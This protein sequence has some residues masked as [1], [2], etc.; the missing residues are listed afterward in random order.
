ML[1]ASEGIT[2]LILKPIARWVEG[3]DSRPGCFVY[4]ERAA[5]FIEQQAVWTVNRLANR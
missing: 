2:P 1:S 3:S 5:V 4:I